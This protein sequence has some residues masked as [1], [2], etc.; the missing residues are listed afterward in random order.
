MTQKDLLILVLTKLIPYWDLA[1]DFLVLAE[2]RYIDDE[3]IDKFL[4]ML[5]KS[6]VSVKNTKDKAALQRGF[7]AIKKIQ[8][9][10]DKEKM[11]EE[12][13]DMLLLDM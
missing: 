4:T 7:D 11:S 3:L 10:E 2:S 12:E 8:E 13:L 1:E 6:I 5:G 9:L